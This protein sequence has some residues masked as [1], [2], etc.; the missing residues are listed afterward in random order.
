MEFYLSNETVKRS[1]FKY[2]KTN[3]VVNLELPLKKGQNISGH[4]CQGHVDY[5][6]K[7]KIPG[8][9]IFDPKVWQRL[10]TKPEAGLIANLDY[11][12]KQFGDFYDLDTDNFDE[13]QQKGAQHLIG[14]QKRLST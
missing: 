8:A 12:T 7:V 13:D 3:D 10:N 11:K 5:V 6:A 2:L 14:Y 4:I 1:K 9:E